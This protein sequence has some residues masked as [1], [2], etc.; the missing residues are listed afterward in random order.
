MFRPR[1]PASTKIKR[2]RRPK[3]IWVV[4]PPRPPEGED[5]ATVHGFGWLY[6]L[7]SMQQ[8]QVDK[9]RFGVNPYDDS[10]WEAFVRWYTLYCRR[11]A[12][13][14]NRGTVF[15]LSPDELRDRLKRH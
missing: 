5:R 12:H 2:T 9:L 1:R 10:E 4:L 15:P 13:K 6:F 8:E 3:E 14:H 11:P 7:G